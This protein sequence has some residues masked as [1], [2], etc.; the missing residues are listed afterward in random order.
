MLPRPP[1][2]PRIIW[3]SPED[4][5]RFRRL[6]KDILSAYEA[7]PG[8]D[9]IGQLPDTADLTRLIEHTIEFLGA[10]GHKPIPEQY[11][12]GVF[13]AG[14]YL[15]GAWANI[16][17]RWKMGDLSDVDTALG[18]RR[19]KGWNKNAYKKHREMGPLIFAEIC[20]EISSG[21][22]RA[23][24]VDKMVRK[25]SV[26]KTQV[27]AWY[28][29]HRQQMER[30]ANDDVSPPGPIMDAFL[31]VARSRGTD[32]DTYFQTALIEVDATYKRLREKDADIS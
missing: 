10:V 7:A 8:A 25:Y 21:E 12:E 30:L 26:S 32:E 17:E 2:M 28:D 9:D 29:N 16:D 20:F 13:L 1:F 18:R 23:A 19:P 5:A 22:S 6:V 15:Q 4:V 14:A 27:D 31:Q 24:A 11:Y 3:D